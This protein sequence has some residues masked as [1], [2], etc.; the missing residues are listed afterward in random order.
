ML[1]DATSGAWSAHMDLQAHRLR[2]RAPPA[3]RMG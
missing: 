2:F 1:T 3:R